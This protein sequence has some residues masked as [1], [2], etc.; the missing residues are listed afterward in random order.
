[1]ILGNQ[2]VLLNK[3]NN[4]YYIMKKLNQQ[5]LRARIRPYYVF[6]PKQVKGTKHFYVSIEEGLRVM[7]DLRGQTSGLEI[8][9]Y[10][11]NVPHG[12]GKIPFQKDMNASCYERCN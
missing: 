11:L 4:D 12:L 3:V 5:L 7:D 9:T 10:I 8:L 6:H 2:T 1:M